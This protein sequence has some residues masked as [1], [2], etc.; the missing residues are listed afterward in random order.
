LNCPYE[1]RALDHPTFLSGR[2]GSIVSDGK[3]VGLLGEIHPEVLE[4]WQIGMPAVA[5]ELDLQR[6][7]KIL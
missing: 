2:A 4:Q 3:T 5:L 7:L 6:L 1:L